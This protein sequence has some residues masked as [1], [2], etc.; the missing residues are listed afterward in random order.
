MRNPRFLS[1]FIAAFFIFVSSNLFAQNAGK[2]KAV[3]GDLPLSME[4]N[5]IYKVAVNITNT[6]KTEWSSEHLHGKADGKFDISKEWST[7][8]KLQPGESTQ[9]Y[10]KIT[11]PGT[12]GK[13]RLKITI[14]NDSKK[15]ISRSRK[16]T[17]VDVTSPGNK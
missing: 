3:M 11:A 10:Y 8:W 13:Y 4:V 2:V 1:V 17:V 15:I 16:I 9:V 12:A 14:Y 5:T 7:E 6:G